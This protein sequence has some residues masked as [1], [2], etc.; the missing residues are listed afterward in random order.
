[1]NNPP[2]YLAIAQ[3]PSFKKFQTARKR[4]TIPI[5]LAFVAFYLGLPVLAGFTK[6]LTHPAIG[7]ISWAWVYAFSLFILTWALGLIYLGKAKQF[8]KL[9]DDVLA[10]IDNLS[11]VSD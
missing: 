6:V 11:A 10:D 2:D 4:F 9:N 7:A 1:M 3:L 5:T 8:D